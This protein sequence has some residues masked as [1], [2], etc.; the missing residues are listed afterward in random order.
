MPRAE[1][2]RILA[3]AAEILPAG[4]RLM[5]TIG[6]SSHPPFVDTMFGEPFFYDSHPPE[7]AL[8][9]PGELGLT[10]VMHEF[11]N[12]PTGGR[13]KGRYA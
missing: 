10:P 13:D 12:V 5:L 1:H 4:G 6:G 2:R 7:T 8:A 3:G 9:I 11:L